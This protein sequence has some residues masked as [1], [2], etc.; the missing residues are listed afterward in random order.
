MRFKIRAKLIIGALSFMLPLLII[1]AIAAG[2]TLKG[3]YRAVHKTGL[4]TREMHSIQNLQILM[5]AALM[6]GNDYIITGNKKY[7]EDFKAASADFEKALKEAE[8]LLLPMGEIAPDAV[9][10]EKEILKDVKIAWTNTK[11]I[12]FVIFSISDP[13]SNRDAARLMEEMD[14]KWA[15]P[16]MERLKRWREVD[17][18][19]HGEALESLKGAV[20][21]GRIMIITGFAMLIAVIILSSLR[22]SKRFTS[23][24]IAAHE[25]MDK[26]AKGD[27]KG[28][29]DIRTGDEIEQLS[30]AM[31]EMSARLE[32]LYSYLG[33]KVEMY[34]SITEISNDAVICLG[35]P[36]AIIL[37]NKRAE[38]MF[39]FS[40]D[41]AMGRGL[42][43]IIV[44]ERYREKSREGLK[45]FFQT[46]AGPL[47]GKTMEH[48]ALRRDGTE[49]PIDI[50]II[51]MKIQDRWQAAGIIRDITERKRAEG[52]IR[53]RLEE[54]KLFRKVTIKRE[55]RMEELKRKVRELEGK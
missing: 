47:I 51:P 30:K 49:F 27:F 23:P 55:L 8:D 24:I 31:N 32:A 43:D 19:E 37:W 26:I 29:L 40:V 46:G 9:K 15:Y 1:I 4:I 44:P 35:E 7:I 2:F 45:E 6:P 38:E 48:V 12:S 16:A 20:R 53:R 18:G 17:I 28:R 36:D 50:S 34:R 3:I 39:G 41:E 54:L 5:Q 22:F 52:E 33:G 10:E 21:Q 13:V 14:Y 11:E 25:M 42:H